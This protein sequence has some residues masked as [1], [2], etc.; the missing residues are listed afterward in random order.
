MMS[1]KMAKFVGTTKAQT[2]IGEHEIHMVLTDK[3]RNVVEVSFAH[4]M[5]IPEDFL[6]EMMKPSEDGTITPKALGLNQEKWNIVTMK[7]EPTIGEIVDFSVEPHI[8]KESPTE[9]YSEYIH[10]KTLKNMMECTGGP[11]RYS[12]NSV[13]ATVSDRHFHYCAC[14]SHMLLIHGDV[15][16]FTKQ[17][18]EHVPDVL[19]PVHV[20]KVMDKLEKMESR[21][22]W[23]VSKSVGGPWTAT[24]TSRFISAKVRWEIKY[25]NWPV[26]RNVIHPQDLDKVENITDERLC[27]HINWGPKPVSEPV[28]LA[29]TLKMKDK[30]TKINPIT[31][32]I[33]LMKDGQGIEVRKADVSCRFNDPVK[34]FKIDGKYLE[35]LGAFDCD[36]DVIFQKD[37]FGDGAGPILFRTTL[38]SAYV[39]PV[40]EPND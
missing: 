33:Y 38:T 36:Y 1:T 34:P 37:H 25:I 26:L 14:D 28:A 5:A 19:F 20:I 35:L 27:F 3:Y 12:L 8:V 32:S 15:K 22:N 31:G 40:I 2:F 21:G 18:G 9:Y 16:V 30:F 4:D 7:D 39:M 10:L 23:L 11:D 29:N 13:G 6:K 24:Y 17:R